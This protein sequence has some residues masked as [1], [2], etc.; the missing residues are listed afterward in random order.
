MVPYDPFAQ[1]QHEL[2]ARVVL[3]SDDLVRRYMQQAAADAQRRG[4]SLD[5]P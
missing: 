5:M 1:Q 2:Q 4:F 3:F